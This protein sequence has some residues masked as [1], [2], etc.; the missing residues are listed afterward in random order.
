MNKSQA[1]HAELGAKGRRIMFEAFSSSDDHACAIKNPTHHVTHPS[2]SAVLN[3]D[4]RMDA[5]LLRFYQAHAPEKVREVPKVLAHFHGRET[6]LLKTLEAKYKVR[7]M[8]DG[9]ALP[10]ANE[11]TEGLSI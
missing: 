10:L 3:T 7:F 5:L 4:V 8:S 2:S 9:T 1:S 6:V 11:Q